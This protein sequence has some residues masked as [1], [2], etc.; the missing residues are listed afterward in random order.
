MGLERKKDGPGEELAEMGVNMLGVGGSGRNGD[1]ESV[2]EKRLWK[3]EGA[4]ATFSRRFPC[5]QKHK[6]KERKKI[7]I[8]TKADSG[9]RKP[10][11][12][13]SAGRAGTSY[14]GRAG[15]FAE[16]R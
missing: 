12:I 4:Y 8:C 6:P 1:I 13:T 7:G 9:R 3:L 15:G 16:V 14:Q 2:K 11:Q 5:L 10:K